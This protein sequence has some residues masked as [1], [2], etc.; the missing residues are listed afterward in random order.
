M[1]V[2]ILNWYVLVETQS[3]TLLALFAGLQ[4][5]GSLVAP[6]VGALADRIGRKRTLAGLRALYAGL[7]ILVMTL[8]LTGVLQPVILFAV[9]VVAG[10]VRPSD[11]V[12]RNALIGDTMPGERIANATGL[13][14]MTLDSARMVGALAGAG[15]LLWLGLGVAYGVVATLYLASFLLT[16][17][18]SHVAYAGGGDRPRPLRQVMDGLAYVARTPALL[19]L[20]W[21][22]FLVNFVGFP[23]VSN[24]GILSY[25]AREVYHLDASG[26]SHLVTCFGIGSLIASI[27]MAATGGSRRPVRLGFFGAVVW[28]LLLIV[29][30][31]T[32]TKMEGMVVLG[33]I[34]VAQGVAM[35]SVAVALLRLA[36]P[37][38]RGRVMGVRMLAVYGLP[39]GLAAA[40]PLTETFGFSVTVVGAALFGLAAIGAIAW[41][42]RAALFGQD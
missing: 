27:V 4:Y 22:A 23:L 9:A 40:G 35:I 10:L 13:S 24:S 41:R 7:A 17:Q 31:F 29:Y 6:A 25:V 32:T 18:V 38:L 28:H 16:L 3:V 39:L 20:M 36:D 21:L 14:R 26:L 19:A 5:I 42:W 1:E 37:N 15:L 33:L 2:L 8:D 11:L 30:G 34:G 12:M